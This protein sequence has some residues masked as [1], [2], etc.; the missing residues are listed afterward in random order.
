L[1]CAFVADNSGQR[2]RRAAIGFDANEISD[3]MSDPF[4]PGRRRRSRRLLLN[5]FIAPHSFQFDASE[6]LLLQGTLSLS[7]ALATRIK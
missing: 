6:I 5:Y 2:E 4:G 1:V 7:F 3:P